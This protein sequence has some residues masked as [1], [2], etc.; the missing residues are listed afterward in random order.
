[1]PFYII[2]CMEVTVHHDPSVH[3]ALIALPTSVIERLDLSVCAVRSI[4]F[5]F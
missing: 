2:F 3:S 1:M 5:L 4:L